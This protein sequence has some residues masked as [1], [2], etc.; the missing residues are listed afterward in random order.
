VVIQEVGSV[1]ESAV[2][3]GGAV[4]LLFLGVSSMSADSLLCHL[5]KK[6]IRPGGFDEA[7]AVVFLSLLSPLYARET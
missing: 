1:L 5:A 7:L 2:C 6:G 4:V 3:V